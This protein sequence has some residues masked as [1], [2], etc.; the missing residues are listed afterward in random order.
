LA[1]TGLERVAHVRVF[2]EEFLPWG[3]DVFVDVSRRAPHVR[4]T[5]IFDVGANVGQSAR[6][7]A[8]LFPD[9]TVWSFE[10]FSSAFTELEQV[11]RDAR[12]RCF[13]LALGAEPSTA[14][15]A[16]A[17]KSDLNS[18]LGSHATPDVPT[19][20]IHVTTLDA[21]TVDH[22]IERIDFL[23]ID[24]EGFDLAVLQGAER[25]LTSG[26]ISLVQVEAGMT[27]KN[28]KHV[29]LETLRVHLEERGYTTFGVYGQTPEWSGEARLRFADVVFAAEHVSSPAAP[30]R[31]R[32]LACR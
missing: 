28:V 2:H 27:S 8:K 17:Q 18:L 7:F 14:T 3:V 22:G 20:T 21:F 11:T 29:P 13:Q 26:A 10:P 5:T 9:A 4:L 30:K 25:L 1:K 16:L 23:K 19:E 32:G 12:V 24:T 31:F 6:R 15:V